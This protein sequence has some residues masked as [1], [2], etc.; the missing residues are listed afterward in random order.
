ME[1]SAI[2]YPN[3]PSIYTYTGASSLPSSSMMHLTDAAFASMPS[4]SMPALPTLH[5]QRSSLAS[6]PIMPP[7]SPSIGSPPASGFAHP[8]SALASALA[9]QEPASAAMPATRSPQSL[10]ND[11]VRE[12]ASRASADSGSPTGR[13]TV[14]A[15]REDWPQHCRSSER[16][17]LLVNTPCMSDGGVPWLH[18]QPPPLHGSSASGAARK[19]GSLA[20][21]IALGV[22]NVIIV[23][24]SPRSRMRCCSCVR[25]RVPLYVCSLR[26]G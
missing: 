21:D 10:I 18:N 8:A 3:P 6:A 11:A 15:Q 5:S 4:S 22:I 25:V 7:G 1:Q 14:T 26:C 16:Q 20:N 2:P 23:R 12:A 19:K 9:A 24:A 17:P 13:A